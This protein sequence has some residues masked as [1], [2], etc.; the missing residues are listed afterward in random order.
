MSSSSI[1]R[2]QLVNQKSGIFYGAAR[3]WDKAEQIEL[4]VYLLYKALKIFIVEGERPIKWTDVK[5]K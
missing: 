4:G 5:E 3:I 2:H 1:V